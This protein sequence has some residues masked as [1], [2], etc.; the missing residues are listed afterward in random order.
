[1]DALFESPWPV[2][3]TGIV[4]EVVL[5]LVFQQTGRKAVLAAMVVVLALVAGGL[6]LERYVV[7][8]REQILL[9]L[10]DLAEAL[11]EESIQPV[12]EFI[13]P[14]AEKTRAQATG[15][16]DRFTIFHAGYSRPKVS[17]NRTR[18]RPTALVEFNAMIEAA[19]RNGQIP[20]N[21]YP[22]RVKMEFRLEGDR[23]LVTDD[24]KYELRRGF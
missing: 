21:R 20:K 24:C 7:T 16:W 3:I 5:G 18:S 15:D 4:I 1:M 19:S 8:D 14:T 13:S 9:T 17:F 2:L 10:D 11:T 12:L 6:W 22:I 23:W